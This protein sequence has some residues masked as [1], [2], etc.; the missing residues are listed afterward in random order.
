M[1]IQVD[2]KESVGPRVSK[3]FSIIPVPES[4]IYPFAV[5]DANEILSLMDFQSPLTDMHILA[6]RDT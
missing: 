4:F 2:I 6:L 1:N 5:C 3:V